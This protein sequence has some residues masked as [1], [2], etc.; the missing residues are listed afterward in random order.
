MSENMVNSPKHYNMGKIEVI[1]AIEDWGLDF[2]LANVITVFDGVRTVEIHR[3]G[4]IFSFVKPWNAKTFRKIKLKGSSLKTGYVWVV[5]GNKQVYVHRLIATLFIPNPQKKPCVNH[6]DGN[7]K[8]NS[9]ENL[10]WVTYSEN[11]LHSYRELGRKTPLGTDRGGGVCYDKRRDNWMTYVGTT[12]NRKY[13][14]RY[15]SES[16]ARE[17]VRKFREKRNVQKK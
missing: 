2:C 8:N 5:F 11:H 1:D 14:G 6:K 13:L 7:K 16:E 15:A 10:E 9:V 4:T 17:A 12:P 3:D